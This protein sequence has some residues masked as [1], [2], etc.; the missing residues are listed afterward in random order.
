MER[1]NKVP[2]DISFADILDNHC[3]DCL[4]GHG[5]TAQLSTLALRQPKTTG[6]KKVLDALTEMC[7]DCF[8]DGPRFAI[9]ITATHSCIFRT[10]LE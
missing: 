3:N 4:E 2:I 10:G 6:E 5:N 8:T 9:S 7:D 1:S